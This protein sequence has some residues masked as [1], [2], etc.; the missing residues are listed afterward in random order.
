MGVCA[1]WVARWAVYLPAFL[2]IGMIA[3]L[4]SAAASGTTRCGARYL[5]P[6]RAIA[7]F[8]RDDR[9]EFIA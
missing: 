9:S 2:L 1:M 6:Q 3:A 8:H 4:A 7:G 5:Q